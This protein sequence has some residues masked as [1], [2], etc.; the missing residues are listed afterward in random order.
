MSR[1]TELSDP[2]KVREA[3][4]ECDRMGREAFL[5]EHGFGPARSYVLIYEGREYDSKAIAGVAFKKQFPSRA[6]PTKFGGLDEAVKALRD[7]DFVVVGRS[8]VSEYLDGAET[9]PTG[10]ESQS[11]LDWTKLI[12]AAVR[13]FADPE[14]DERERKYKIAIAT[15]IREIML[16][17]QRATTWIDDLRRALSSERFYNHRYNLTTHWDHTW[18]LKLDGDQAN[19]VAG[20]FDAYLSTEDPV[21]RMAVWATT[22]KEFAPEENQRPGSVIALGSVFNFAIDPTQ[23]P[24]VKA[25]PFSDAE[26]ATGFKVVNSDPA[27]TYAQH[28]EF[29]ELAEDAL[30]SA[31][32]QVRD[33]LDVQSVIWEFHHAKELA[34]KTK[35]LEPP[36]EPTSRQQGWIRDELILAMEVAQRTGSSATPKEIDELTES[37]RKLPIEAQ[38][39][40]SSGFRDRQEVEEVL[41]E[42][43]KL[44]ADTQTAE[45]VEGDLSHQVVQ[46]FLN[47]PSALSSVAEQIRAAATSN[48]GPGVFAP[49]PEVSEAPEGRI[50]TGIH[51]YRERNPR[52]AESK[53]RGALE[54][55]GKLSCEGCG[56]VFADR[57]GHRGEG[58]IECHHLTPVSELDNGAKTN[59]SDLALV[60][61]NCHRM[62]HRSQPW[63]TMS[64]LRNLVRDDASREPS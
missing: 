7:M 44:M 34:R 32:V 16:D 18:L 30:K 38:L 43:G 3:I 62:I 20:A 46:H 24:I 8:E 60:C 57:Y 25:F 55:Y 39:S 17:S 22:V 56:F 63:L 42:I 23:L 40:A 35:G 37:L 59:L 49:D 2:S 29:S 50:M 15:R 28:L 9:P 14:F 51:T 13:S 47:S 53:K 11:V 4:A 10:D 5:R 12:Q 52:L 64:E 41:E 48:F 21:D 31:G 19:A 58:F 54:T 27:A 45:R 36:T 1:I 61:A 26:R 6:M 33:M